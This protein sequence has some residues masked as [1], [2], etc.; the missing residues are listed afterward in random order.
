MSFTQNTVIKKGSFAEHFPF[1]IKEWNFKKNI[2]NPYK[3]LKSSR[4]R[5]HWICFKCNYKWETRIDHRTISKSGCKPC[6]RSEA[7]KKSYQT[8]LGKSRIL[9]DV[10]KHLV[11]QWHPT[12]NGNLTPKNVSYGSNKKVYWICSRGHVWP[13]T[14]SNRNGLG[15]NC[16]KCFPMTSLIELRF[17][18]ELKSLLMTETIWKHKIGKLEIDIFFPKKKLGIEIDGYPWHKNMEDKDLKKNEKLELIGLKIIRVRDERLKII[19]KKNVF[20]DSRKYQHIGSIKNLLKSKYFKSFLNKKEIL[21]VDK[22]LRSS[23]FINEKEFKEIQLNLPRPKKERS[24]AINFPELIKQWNFKKNTVD[25]EFYSIGSGFIA[26]WICEKN[27]EWKSAISSRTK[28]HGCEKC[29]NKI[30]HS[31]YNFQL[32]EPKLVKYYHPTLNKKKPYE[33]TPRS[34][35][36]VFW[37][38][39]KGHVTKLDFK[40]FARKPM[41]KRGYRCKDCWKIEL[42]NGTRSK[43]LKTNY[44]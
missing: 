36:K 8:K 13:A 16:P 33:F 18:T 10:N 2:V 32:K 39:P 22:Y 4:E 27:H 23:K 20:I 12:K 30:A 40:H 24:F 41:P 37:L 29:L 17:F 9:H 34:T 11:H 15:H 14:I 26:H 44:N 21:K 25:P 28:S 31:K 5:V 42:K 7:Y 19:N 43:K 1:L 35:K 3:I 6:K 38:C